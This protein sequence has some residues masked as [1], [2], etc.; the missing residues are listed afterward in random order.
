MS[1]YTRISVAEVK[2]RFSDVLGAVR[3][4]QRRF[5]IERNGTPVAALVPLGDRAPH[6]AAAS[7][8]LAL[9][10]AFEDAPELSRTLDEVVASRGTQRARPAPPLAP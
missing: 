2:R 3:Y 1:D 8:F 9:V 4:Q 5:V 6:P 7:G 10:G